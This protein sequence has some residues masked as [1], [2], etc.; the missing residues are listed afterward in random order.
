[1]KNVTLLL[2]LTITTSIVHT[3]CVRE[4]DMEV[5]I[6]VETGIF[7]DPRDGE[8]YEWLKIDDQVWMAEN[9]KFL[10]SVVG[11]S[12][13]SHVAS[14]YYVHSYEGTDVEEAK[15]TANYQTFGALYNWPAALTACPTG[16]HLPNYEEWMQLIERVGKNPATKLKARN[17]WI[18]DGNGL[19]SYGFR[20]LSGGS[21][22]Q[23]DPQNYFYD[24]GYWG[25]WWLPDESEV[26]NA[27]WYIFMGIYGSG[28]DFGFVG[29]RGNGLSVRCLRN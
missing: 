22:L 15:G 29:H 23:G 6:I 5:D 1:M 19:D 18:G 24:I 27:A 8:T 9:L 3:S 17:S 2:I 16:W 4:D 28:V 25:F 7:T 11:S 20:A 26:P 21:K 13:D 10:P 12:I 14:F